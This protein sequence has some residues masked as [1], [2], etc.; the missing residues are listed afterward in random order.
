MESVHNDTNHESERS[1]GKK[2]VVIYGLSGIIH[3]QVHSI[4]KM[5]I[6]T[7]DQTSDSTMEIQSTIH[8]ILKQTC[9]FRNRKCRKWRMKARNMGHRSLSKNTSHPR[10]CILLLFLHQALGFLS[11]THRSLSLLVSLAGT[12]GP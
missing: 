8:M 5:G 2:M 9:L 11:S 1:L 4:S 10:P 3:P 12:A 6:V 7:L